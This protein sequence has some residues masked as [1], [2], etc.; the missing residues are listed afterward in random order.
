MTQIL[1][2][3]FEPKGKFKTV[4]EVTQSEN[5]KEMTKSFKEE[6]D[7]LKKIQ[8]LVNLGVPVYLAGGNDGNDIFNL[9]SLVDGVNT[10]GATDSKGKIEK[11]SPTNSL[12]NIFAQ[13]TFNVSEI[14]DKDGKVT[15]YDYTGDGKPDIP[16]SDVSGKGSRVKYF[17][18]KSIADIKA[19]E[20]ERRLL[21]NLTQ[22]DSENFFNIVS[23]NKD[24]ETTIN[25][26]K[27][28]LF[29]SKLKEYG[30]FTDIE[31]QFEFKTDKIGKL[32]FDPDNSGREAVNYIEG[33]SFAA[34]FALAYDLKML[35]QQKI[36]DSKITINQSC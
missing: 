19:D 13:G 15:A 30:K 27:N 1:N 29:I 24:I 18:G 22:A 33:T 23:C 34:P 28:K 8:E 11:Y 2:D 9:Y 3:D 5:L 12:V 36:K 35:S 6:K 20:K 7:G 31:G 21:S 16:V 32:I 4:M 10:V 25:N 26:M 17:I 14:K